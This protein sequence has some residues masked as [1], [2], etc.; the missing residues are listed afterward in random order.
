[1]AKLTQ[2]LIFLPEM[3]LEVMVRDVIFPEHALSS[4]PV[5][6]RG[7]IETGTNEQVKMREQIKN[8]MATV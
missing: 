3:E 4:S 7:F 8:N 6:R 1:M 5:R 2:S